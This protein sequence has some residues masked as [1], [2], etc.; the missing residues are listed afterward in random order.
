MLLLVWVSHPIEEEQI[1]SQ[2]ISSIHSCTGCSCPIGA[3]F[4]FLSVINNLMQFKL[5]LE[6][7]VHLYFPINGNALIPVMSCQATDTS[8]D[9]ALLNSAYSYI[10]IQ[11]QMPS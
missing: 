8:R 11:G 4:L 1:E 5:V 6:N 10:V 3:L 2:L 9:A 7:L